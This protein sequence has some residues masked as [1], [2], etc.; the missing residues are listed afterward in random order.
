MQGK[1]AGDE[2]VTSPR[3][4]H[5][6]VKEGAEGTPQH[7]ALLQRLDPEVEGEDEQEDGDGLVVVAASDG[8]GDVARGNAHE[9]G[10]Q[11]TS[12]GR[13][14]HLIGKEVGG[15][16]GKTREGGREKDADIPDINGD[17]EGS[18]GVVD[19][20]TG[21]HEARV[22]GAS[23]DTAEGVPCPVIEPIPEVVEAVRNEVLGSAEVEPGVNWSRC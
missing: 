11:E 3:G 2:G 7:G 8:T 1:Q 20:A 19:G 18:E 17:R 22:E 10:S 23:R 5:V 9:Q 15:D 13:G 14:G 21:H 12:R 16:G 4:N 6:A